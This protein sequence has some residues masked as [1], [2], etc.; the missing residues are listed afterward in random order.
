MGRSDPLI[1][2]ERLTKRFPGVVALD[3]VSFDVRA[4]SC[5]AL[6]G[7]NGAGK[8]TLGRL[9]AGIYAPDEGRIL[10]RGREVRFASPLE[11]MRAGV[12]IVHQELSFCP[13][14]SVAENLCLGA[15]PSRWG[16]LD[17][18]TMRRRA[19]ELLGQV[20]A[21]LDVDRPV[22]LLP[23]AA[24]QLVQIAAAVGVG[25]ATGAAP[26][27]GSILIMDE[28]TSS[29]SHAETEHLFA[30][31]ERLRRQG[32]TILYISHRLEEVFRLC[33]RLTVLRDGR[34]VRTLDVA[35]T[36]QDEVVR[37]M[38]GRS[39]AEYFPSHLAE[40]RGPE[41]LRVESLSSPGKFADIS[42]SL[43]AGEVLGLA[44]LVGSGRSQIAQ[45]IFGLDPRASGR[46]FVRG[47][48]VRIENPRQAMA[49][50]IGYLP[51]DRKRQGLILSMGAR[52]NLSLPSLERLHRL[53]WIRQR[54]ERA[55]ARD[56]FERLRVRMA[57]MDAPV[58]ALSGGNQQKIAL[59]KWL[60]SRCEIL[61]IDEP[62]RG[63][64]VGAK[65]EIRA[66]IDELA[67]AGSAVLMISSE[68]PE[69]LNLS[70]RILV[71]RQGRLVGRL[72]REHADEVS[73]IRLMTGVRAA[74]SREP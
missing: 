6:V 63:V 26:G 60:A 62:T 50:G 48:Q 49:A 74:R 40:H 44:G 27:P 55:L 13:N 42:F 9:L 2:F 70:T 46:V 11:A 58:V 43:H 45:A 31:I 29:L 67:R 57:G 23:T 4:G 16:F 52:A 19:R 72:D 14:L 61:L 35:R 59:A 37:L 64:D 25:T 32:V 18:R 71:L 22:G 24:E 34:C 69:I 28:P 53:G 12:G 1:R 68:L 33:D 66:L 5:H 7:E 10:L 38:I 65:S 21:D 51:E 20:G 54:A 41:L 17:R 30:L 47:R 3:K 39:L 56:Y 36:D 8:S 15:L 73:L